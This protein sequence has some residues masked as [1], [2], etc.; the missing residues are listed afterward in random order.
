MKR[1]GLIAWVLYSVVVFNACNKDDENDPEF[2]PI[3]GTWQGTSVEYEFT[4]SGLGVGVPGTEEFDGI[5]EFKD[6]GTVIYSYNGTESTG[7][8]TVVG[9]KLT[10]DVNFTTS[11]P[12]AAQ[13]FTIKKLTNGELQ[14][15]FED[16][17]EFEVP[18]LGTFDGTIEATI[19]FDR[20]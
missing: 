5:V 18:D 15:Y 9:D 19:F 2:A 11:F 12:F 14:L 1:I 17:G 7:T 16:E 6:D 8:Y 20:Q 3:T 10:T 13:S 4:P